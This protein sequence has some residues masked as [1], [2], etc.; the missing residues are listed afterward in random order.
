MRSPRTPRTPC[1]PSH[2]AATIAG[3]ATLPPAAAAVFGGLPSLRPFWGSTHAGLESCRARAARALAVTLTC[4]P[5]A[6]G[7]ARSG[8]RSSPA[9]QSR[10]RSP[11]RVVFEV[12][13]TSRPGTP[14]RGCRRKGVSWA[15]SRPTPGPVPAH[16]E[17]IYETGSGCGRF[18]RCQSLAFRLDTRN[19]AR[20]RESTIFSHCFPRFHSPQVWL[21]LCPGVFAPVLIAAAQRPAGRH[22]RAE[23]LGMPARDCARRP[24]IPR[25][26]FFSPSRFS[27]RGRSRKPLVFRWPFYL[28][29]DPGEHY[30]DFRGMREDQ[31]PRIVAPS[32]RSSRRRHC[33]GLPLVAQ[34]A[35]ALGAARRGSS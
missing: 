17:R 11:L 21:C 20:A 16:A 30:G 15:P 19:L 9:G 10:R 26:A 4:A 31:P 24:S 14:T 33:L 34:P 3:A 1:A 25:R 6:E 32:R 23:G 5:F 27:A 35:L 29:P 12:L 13:T 22:V 8:Q 7:S 18:P 28:R 2:A